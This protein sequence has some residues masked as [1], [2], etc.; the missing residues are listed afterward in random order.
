M[1]GACS[2]DVTFQIAGKSKLA[3]KYNKST[4]GSGL[5]A[6]MAEMSSGTFKADIHDITATDL[7]GM[8]LMTNT[9]VKEGVKQEYRT[10]HVW[11]IQN[12]KPLA[13][14]EYPRDMYQYDGI[15]S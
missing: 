1:L 14:Y 15:W 8:V 2:D 6:K 13:G 11:R 4:L 7:H 9:I 5:L 12:G 3:G 10:V